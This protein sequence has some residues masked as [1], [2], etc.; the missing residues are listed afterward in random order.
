MLAS[1]FVTPPLPP[2]DV[3]KEAS[4]AIAGHVVADA[5]VFIFVVVVGVVDHT[6]VIICVIVVVAVIAHI[7]VVVVVIVVVVV[8]IVVAVVVVVVVVVVAVDRC[9]LKNQP[10]LRFFLSRVLRVFFHHVVS[11]NQK[12]SAIKFLAEVP[13]LL[14]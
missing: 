12:V 3:D 11:R 10:R 14:N 6:I 2:P 5:V 1:A 7:E 4:R 8:V 9:A 13:G